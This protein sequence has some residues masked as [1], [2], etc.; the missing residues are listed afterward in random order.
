[1]ESYGRNLDPAAADS[2]PATNL[3]QQEVQD[4][5]YQ[6]VEPQMA[7]E[8]PTEAPAQPLEESIDPTTNPQAEHFRALRD[9]VDRLKAER[10]TERKDYQLQLDMLRANIAE[11]IPARAPEPPKPMFDGMRDDD[12]PNVADLRKEWEQREANYQARLEEMQVAQMHP[13]YAEVLDKYVAPLIKQKPHLAEGIQGA[14]NK[15]LFAYELG[16]MAQQMSDNAVPRPPQKSETAQRIVD[17]ARKP[18]TLSQAGGTAAISKADYYANL[19]DA[20]FMKLAS[21]NLEQI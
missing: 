19:S 16:K 7:P 14:Q 12:I 15:A 21:R 3:Y 5:P 8:Q 17:N 11:K 6:Q 20:D 2:T 9:E 18:G 10:D 13:D 1:M 4:V